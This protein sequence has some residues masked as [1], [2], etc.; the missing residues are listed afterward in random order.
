MS[1][2]KPEAVEAQLEAATHICMQQGAQ[3]TALRRV[4][5]GLVLEA[6][7]PSTAYQ[8]LD[9]LKEIRKGAAPPTIYRALDFLLEQRLIHKIERL[10]AFIPCTEAH[11]HPHAAQFLICRRCGAVAEIEDGAV[12]RALEHAAAREGFRLGHAV[13]EL[14]GTCAACAGQ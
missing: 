12:S 2:R 3:L 4:V 1:L 11:H 8:L 9:R 7:G 13:V 5:L 6:E 10:N 14:D